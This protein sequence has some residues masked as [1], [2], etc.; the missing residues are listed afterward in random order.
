MDTGPG[1]VSPKA[2]VESIRREFGNMAPGN[3]ADPWF[4]TLTSANSES[5]QFSCVMR[6]P[7]LYACLLGNAVLRLW[8]ERD[9]TDHMGVDIK[10]T[11]VGPVYRQW[12]VCSFNLDAIRIQVGV[13]SLSKR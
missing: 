5:R 7:G 13:Q 11:H 3:E 6:L 8:V 4:F 10:E 12:N 9:E 2:G 1:K